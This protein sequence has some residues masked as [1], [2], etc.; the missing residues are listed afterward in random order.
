MTVAN[1]KFA[2]KNSNKN[3]SRGQE[4]EDC[5]FDATKVLQ[6]SWEISVF[7]YNS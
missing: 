4:K 5:S 7:F 3:P 2:E 6:V 1:A